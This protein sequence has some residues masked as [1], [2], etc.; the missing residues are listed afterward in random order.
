MRKTLRDN[1]HPPHLVRHRLCEAEVVVKKMSTKTG[2][3]RITDRETTC[4]FLI[5]HYRQESIIFA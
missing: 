1:E 2:N 4:T 5:P 3:D